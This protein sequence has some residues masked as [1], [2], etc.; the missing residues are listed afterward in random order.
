MTDL[1]SRARADAEWA[2]LLRQWQ[3]QPPAQPRPFFYQRVRA[4][5]V[6]DAAARPLLP[7]WLRR[8]AYAAVLVLLGVA[9]SGDCTALASARPTAPAPSSPG[10]LPPATPLR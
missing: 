5:L 7:A 9:L 10:A 2:A 6:A 4:R 8:P 1:D 3:A